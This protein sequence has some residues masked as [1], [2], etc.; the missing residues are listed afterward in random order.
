[1]SGGM[2]SFKLRIRK[3]AYLW[4]GSQLVANLNT[5]IPL[6]LTLRVDD[7]G[8]TIVIGQTRFD[9]GNI[10]DFTLGKLEAGQSYTVALNNICGLYAD[11]ENRGSTYISCTVHGAQ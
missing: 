10:S 9:G 4:G 2:Y 3:K 11:P 8:E 5:A 7:A 1:M 6:F